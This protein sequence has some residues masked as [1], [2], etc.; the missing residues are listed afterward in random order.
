MGTRF[1]DALNR[2]CDCIGV[3]RQALRDRLSADL[4]DSGVP[5]KLLDANSHLFAMSPVSKNSKSTLTPPPR[6]EASPEPWSRRPSRLS[7]N[8]LLV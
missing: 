3:D 8:L 6:V 4:R 1:A 2:D 5:E 7:R